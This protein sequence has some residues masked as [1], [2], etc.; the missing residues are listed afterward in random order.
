MEVAGDGHSLSALSSAPEEVIS[1]VLDSIL[2]FKV[3]SLE[4]STRPCYNNIRS[5]SLLRS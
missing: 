2:L 4:A 5:S 1:V 3:S